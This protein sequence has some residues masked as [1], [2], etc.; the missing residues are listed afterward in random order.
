MS[1]RTGTPYYFEPITKR[2]ARRR[3]ERGEPIA[4]SQTREHL[5][6]SRGFIPADMGGIDFAALAE[7]STDT[8]RP[9]SVYWFGPELGVGDLAMW[10]GGDVAPRRVRIVGE[11]GVRFIYRTVGGAVG[12][13]AHDD[14]ANFTRIG[15]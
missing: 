5:I 12:W 11:V 7:L 9:R 1:I 3:W 13:E 14:R 4:V 8:R 10:T 15:A 2:E 6:R